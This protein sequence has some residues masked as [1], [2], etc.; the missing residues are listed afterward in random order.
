[1]VERKVGCQLNLRPVD[2]KAQ[3]S[4][5]LL[6]TT[7]EKTPSKEEILGTCCSSIASVEDTGYVSAQKWVHP[8]FGVQH[9]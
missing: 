6:M 4:N 5:L 8:L 2:Q 7:E 1:M 3:M 9:S